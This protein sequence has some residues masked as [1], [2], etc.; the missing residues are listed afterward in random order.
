MNDS[1]GLEK[2]G[3]E[4]NTNQSSSERT[5][6]GLMKLIEGSLSCT[7]EYDSVYKNLDNTCDDPADET[8]SVPTLGEVA[9]SVAQ[10]QGTKM[11]EK[12]YITHKILCCTFLLGLENEG[13]D[14]NSKLK[15]YL[16]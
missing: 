3:T 13:H 1:N 6:S 8:Q 16:Q 10:K 15:S 11:D 2:N 5:F 9:R 14:P 7:P 4:L 12:Q